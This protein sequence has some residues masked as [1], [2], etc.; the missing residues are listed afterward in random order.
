VTE[1]AKPRESNRYVWVGS[2]VFAAILGGAILFVAF[3]P[4]IQLR[5]HRHY[6]RKGTP[7]RQVE[8]LVW[9]CEHRLRV[10]MTKREVER[11]LG[12][13]LGRRF[14]RESIPAPLGRCDV[15]L[16]PHGSRTPT[17]QGSLSLRLYWWAGEAGQAKTLRS[18]VD[19]EARKHVK[20]GWFL[21]TNVVLGDKPRVM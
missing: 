14:E 4:E 9:M 11:V 6:F 20:G 5:Y 2:A 13:K 19:I 15:S 12:E 18:A 16:F 1:E 10:G 21:R 17:A 3:W 8:A 7:E